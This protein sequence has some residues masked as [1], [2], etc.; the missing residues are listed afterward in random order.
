MLLAKHRE[1]YRRFYL[2]PRVLAR[3]FASFFSRGGSKRFF[4]VLKASV[5][6]LKPKPRGEPRHS[7]A[8]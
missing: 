3:Y 4:S 8:L 5:F 2:R 6:V 1:M 7:E